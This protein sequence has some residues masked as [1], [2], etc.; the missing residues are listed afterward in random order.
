VELRV[1]KRDANQKFLASE[2]LLERYKLMKAARLETFASIL[3]EALQELKKRALDSLSAKELLSLISYLE[4]RFTEEATTVS[5][6]T[7]ETVSSWALAG[8]QPLKIP[9][10]D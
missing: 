7:D 2:E 6:T 4:D 9:L 1:E 10:F 5:Y 8:D 3:S